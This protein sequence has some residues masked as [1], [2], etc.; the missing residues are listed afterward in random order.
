MPSPLARSSTRRRIASRTVQVL[1][2]AVVFLGASPDEGWI[3]PLYGVAIVAAPAVVG[4]LCDRPFGPLQRTWVSVGLAVHPVGALYDL[5]AAF[6]WYDHVAHAASAT[7]VAGLCY[8][9]ATGLAHA[10]RDRDL[11][12]VAHGLVLCGVL[13]AGVTWE[14]YELQVASLVVY[15]PQDTVAD[16]TYDVL[17]W[18]VVAPRWRSLLGDRPWTLAARRRSGREG[19]A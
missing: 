2:A 19:P 9:A 5:Y 12:G 16:L 4:R 17:G 3:L 7:L 14:L 8:L 1:A 6:W 18:L 13:L 11:P 15:G 10:G